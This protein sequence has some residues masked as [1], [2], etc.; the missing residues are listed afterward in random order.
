MKLY[1]ITEELLEAATGGDELEEQELHQ[2]LN[3]LAMD[4]SEKSENIIKAVRNLEAFA[5]GCGSEAERLTRQKRATENRVKWLKNYLRT[6]MAELGLKRLEAGT[7]KVAIQKNPARVVIDDPGQIPMEYAE[8]VTEL[9]IDKS[10][11]KS[12]LQEGQQI[13]GVHIE[14]GESLRIR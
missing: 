13:P 14:Q 11:L 7:F 6:N 1:E 3:A 10:A 2:R 12:A 9:R 4:F 5:T 8:E